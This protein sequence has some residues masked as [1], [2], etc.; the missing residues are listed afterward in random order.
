MVHTV[1]CHMSVLLGTCHLI[2]ING[3]GAACWA[4]WCVG[5][6]ENAVRLVWSIFR[7]H[8][9]HLSIFCTYWPGYIWRRKSLRIPKPSS[10]LCDLSP[11]PSLIDKDKLTTVRNGISF[12]DEYVLGGIRSG[13]TRCCVP[14]FPIFFC[15]T[16][17]NEPRELPNGDLEQEHAELKNQLYFDNYVCFGRQAITWKRSEKLGCTLWIPRNRSN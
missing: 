12:M 4:R 13:G 6:S 17:Q 11:M 15:Y 8:L 14:A 7:V 3:C 5:D 16:L 2:E 1:A 9:S 10:S